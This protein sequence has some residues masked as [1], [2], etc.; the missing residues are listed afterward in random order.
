MLLLADGLLYTV[1]VVFHLWDGLRYHN[2]IW[3]GFVLGGA[4]CH[5]AAILAS[6]VLA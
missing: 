3:H 2:A 4:G 6:V 5:C 1:G